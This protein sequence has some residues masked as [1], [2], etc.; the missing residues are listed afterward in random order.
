MARPSKYET[1]VQP[2]LTLVEAWA[3][4]G[5]TLDQIAHN[6]SIHVATLCEY[7][8]E[9]NELNESLK[10]GQEEVDVIVENALLKRALGYEYEEITYEHGKEVK[11]VSKQVVPDTTAQIFWLKN[12]KP[13]VWRDRQQLEHSGENGGPLKVVFNIPRPK[14]DDEY[15]QE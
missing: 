8:K 15:A 13:N 4:D 10:R 7:K 6:L 5:L 2:K 14:K 11:R 9:Y 3:R 1:H 12:R